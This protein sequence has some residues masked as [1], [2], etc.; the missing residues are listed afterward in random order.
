[1]SCVC[2]YMYMVINLFVILYQCITFFLVIIYSTHYIPYTHIHCV[3]MLICQYIS[4]LLLLPLS[5][6]YLPL[7]HSYLPLAQ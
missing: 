2:Y 5:P 6:S 1:M 7:S 3:Y 4:L